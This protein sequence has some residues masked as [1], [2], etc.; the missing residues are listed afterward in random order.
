MQPTRRS[1]VWPPL[2]RSSMCSSGYLHWIMGVRQIY[3]RF[4]IVRGGHIMNTGIQP[5]ANCS[6]L[7]NIKGSGGMMPGE[8]IKE[9]LTT[10][11]L[12]VVILLSAVTWLMQLSLKDRFKRDM[13]QFK[14]D[15]KATQE[16]IARLNVLGSL[17]A[18]VAQVALA[19]VVRLQE[20]CKGEFPADFSSRWNPQS[21]QS[22]DPR[23][24]KRDTTVFRILRLFA[25]IEIYRQAAAG[26]SQFDRLRQ[27]LALWDRKLV[28]L[29][30]S[31]GY[32]R[33]SILWRDA[34]AELSEEMSHRSEKWDAM[35]PLN[36]APFVA[37]MQQTGSPGDLLGRKCSL[38]Q[39]FQSTCS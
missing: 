39:H 6:P 25:E 23:A 2:I 17:Q 37:L 14:S 11:S 1:T 19:V 12:P 9:L 27:I 33:E 24:N 10:Y 16:E 34:I 5:D 26:F 35:K 20:R 29:F 22:L 31:S 8:I 18:P 28:P 13:E 38:C 3:M 15:L 30:A 36:W 21:L 32:V 4:S 7:N